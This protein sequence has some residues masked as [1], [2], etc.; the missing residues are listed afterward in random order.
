MTV[1]ALIFDFDGP[2]LDT[3]LPEDPAPGRRSTPP[4]AARW[5]SDPWGGLQFGTADIVFSPYDDL[6]AGDPAAIGR[7]GGR[8]GRTDPGG[9][10]VA[11]AVTSKTRGRWLLRL[12]VASVSTRE[13][14]VGHLTR[15]GPF[16]TFECVE[17]LAMMSSA[18]SLIRRSTWRRWRRWG[19]GRGGDRLRGLAERRPGGQAR[20]PLLRGDP[21]GVTGRLPLDQPT[22][23]SRSPL[24]AAAE[25]ARTVQA[26][27]H[28]DGAAGDRERRRC[29]GSP[30]GA[31]DEQQRGYPGGHARLWVRR[32]ARRSG[33]DVHGQYAIA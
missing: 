16:G 33:D 10:R 19:C 23:S 24:A 7:R 20:R 8:A 9:G 27:W 21:D 3:E 12:Y 1:R 2:I 11:R 18:P 26:R 6:E 17:L 14:V 13:W 5:P 31:A 4:T 15:L 25:V 29:S 30:E 28:A 32:A 22:T